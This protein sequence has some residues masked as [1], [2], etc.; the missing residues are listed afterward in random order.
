MNK[1]TINHPDWFKIKLPAGEKFTK[2]QALIKNHSLNTVCTEARCPNKAECWG[3]GVFTFMILGDICTRNCKF[4]AV[5]SGIPEEVDPDESARVSKVIKEINCKYIVITSVDRDD[6][7]DGG[8]SVYA[9]TINLI[10]KDNP[11]CKIEV[12]IPDFQGNEESLEIVFHAKPDVLAHNLETVPSLYSR[13]RQKAIYERSLKVL[14]L[15]KSQNLVTKSGLMLGLGEQREEIINVMED[16]R[17]INCDILTLGQYLQPTKKQLPVERYITPREFQE[18]KEIA[19]NKGFLRV[20]SSPLVR[21]S[22]HA[23]Y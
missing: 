23:G 14:D 8:A 10:K 20:E 6:L 9:K 13:V 19:L 18:L 11:D 4:C 21:S 12:L 1:T 2:I 16:L 22:Y 7:Q 15:A 3:N 17:K 5:T